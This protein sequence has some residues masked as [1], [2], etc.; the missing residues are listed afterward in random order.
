MKKTITK[1]LA[2][3]AFASL[4]SIN[5][6]A[7]PNYFLDTM[8]DWYRD[9]FSYGHL[10]IETMMKNGFSRLQA[11]EIQNQMKDLLESDSAYLKFEAK[12]ATKA[13]F[14]A[15]SAKLVEALNQAI[16]KV[17]NQN[18][19]ESGFQA[20]PLQKHEFYVAFDMDETLMVQWYK[21]G[22]KGDKYYD[23]KVDVI[24][25]I[26]RPAFT[27]PNYVSMTPN[28]EEALIDITK[29]PGC[30]GVIFFTA[31]EDK[32]AHD[33]VDRLKIDGQPARKFV[34][35]VFTRNHLVR[36]AKATKL[37]KDLRIIDE[38]LEHVIIIDD[39]PTRIFTKQKKNLREFPKYNPDEYLKAKIGNRDFDAVNYYEK[40]LPI[41]VDEIR[42]AAQYAKS[43]H[44]TFAKAYYPYSMDASAE[45]IMLQRQ[46]YS[47]KDTLKVLRTQHQW[48]EPKFFFYKK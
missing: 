11:V 6:F 17:K 12:G 39:N 29:I 45:M 19:F 40:L 4:L 5:T 3:T 14:K 25:S 33:I 30:K 7:N 22:L 8:P 35:G 27:S 42:E 26:F 16:D 21:E 36:N 34:K 24:D 28:W 23:L 43:N 2:T 37:S 10:N 47:F 48:F 32:A 13:L 15:K 38:S 1:L 44:T 41:V 9:G 31:K 46:G 20:I 18:Y